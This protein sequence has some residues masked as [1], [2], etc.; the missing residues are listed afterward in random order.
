MASSADD[1]PRWMGPRRDNT[2]NEKNLLQ[3][4]PAG[5]PKILWR[6][7]IANGFAGPAVAEGRIVVGDFVTDGDFRLANFE[8]LALKGTER[9][10]CLDEISGKI[11]WQHELPIEYSISYPAGPRCTPII[12]NGKVYTLGA[13]GNLFC[14]SLA[15]GKILW[16]KDLKQE[17]KTTAALW[18]YAAH[19]LIDGE[20]LITLAGGPGSH[21]VALNKN[22]GTEVW[23]SLTAVE[24][25]YSPPTIIQAGGV[26]QL[27]LLRPDAVSSVNPDN[28]TE[29][30]SLPYE[31]DSG[32]IIMSP[33][34]FGDYLY[35]AGYARK[36]ILIK[37]N[38]DKPAAEVVWANRAG[39]TISP[40]N[41]QPFLDRDSQILYGMD[42]NGD[43]RATQLPEG[44]LLWATSQPVG[45]RRAANATAFL[46]RAG[47]NYWFFN[48]QGELVIAKLNSTGFEEI[49]RVKVIEPTNVAF[50]RDVAWSMPAF[51]NGHAYIRNDK[52][53]ICVQLSVEK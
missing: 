41:V 48:D 27:I 52:E 33:I 17:Y 5:G 28:G 14:F 46:V 19:P 38:S 47:D 31:A 16:S 24:Q 34:Q 53:I 42:Q 44:K 36:S 26:R 37:L 13:E 23:R 32:S 30:W 1:W 35:A 12:E 4:F 20:N 7:T 50:G 15:D 8:R 29:Y 43:L 18:G 11:L 39:D 10:L 21:V 40:V 51:A 9:V 22:T 6:S 3:S 45:K 25:G 2:W 49:D